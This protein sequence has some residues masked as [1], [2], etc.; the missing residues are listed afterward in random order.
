MGIRGGSGVGKSAFLNAGVIGYLVY[1]LSEGYWGCSIRSAQL[2]GSKAGAAAAQ[3]VEVLLRAALT[4]LECDA[5]QPRLLAAVAETAIEHQAQFAVQALA[6]LVRAKGHDHRLLIGLDQFEELIDLRDDPERGSIWEA[7][8]RFIAAATSATNVGVLYTIQSNREPLLAKDRILGPIF[9]TGESVELLFPTQ[10]LQDIITCPFQAV[11]INLEPDL[12]DEIA[13]RIAA[14]YRAPGAA[15]AETLLPLVSRMLERLHE[16]ALTHASP[17][18]PAPHE[19]RWLKHEQLADMSQLLKFE[20]AIAVDAEAAFQEA[21]QACGPNWTNDRLGELLRRLVRL[22][23]AQRDHL[24]LP[25]AALPWGDARLL[26]EALVRRRLLTAEPGGVFQ[27]AHEAVVRSWPT[28]AAWLDSER[29]LMALVGG[30]G[31]RADEWERAGRSAQLLQGDSD[32]AAELLSRWHS[33]L[34]DFDGAPV[35]ASDALLRDFAL[36]L[37]MRDADPKRAVRG[38]EL[39]SRHVHLAASYGDLVLLRRFIELD[40]ECVH[41]ERKDRRSPLFALCRIGSSEGVALLL[42]AGARPDVKDEDGWLPL[43]LAA[44][45]GHVRCVEALLRAGTPPDAIGGEDTTALDLAVGEAHMGVIELLL[46]NRVE[47]NRVGSDGRT[48]L[49]IAAGCGHVAVVGRL[50]ATGADPNLR[51][52]RSFTP[53]HAAANFMADGTLV[54][55][56]ELGAVPDALARYDEWGSL[57]HLRP[58]PLAAAT[59]LHIAC[60]RGYREIADQLLKFFAPPDVDGLPSFDDGTGAL[61]P[62]PEGWTLAHLVADRGHVALVDVLARA[63]APIDQPAG[64]DVTPLDIALEDAHLEV[65]RQLILAGADINRSRAGVGTY[66]QRVSEA[67]Q[68]EKVTLL[69]ELGATVDRA[70]VGEDAALTRAARLGRLEVVRYLL[71]QG[72]DSA[73]RGE[74]GLIALQR[75]VEGNH[76]AVARCLLEHQPL[77]GDSDCYGRSVLHLACSHPTGDAQ[78]LVELLLAYHHPVD[79]RDVAGW[80]P[81]HCAAQSGQVGAAACLLRYEADV[82]AISDQ[83]ALSALQVAAEVGQ[84]ELIALLLAAGA[85][86]Q[87]H[88]P[89]RA[90][91]VVL[92]IENRN[93]E[94]AKLLLEDSSL[95]VRADVTL[96]AF[97]VGQFH[98]R[99]QARGLLG[100]LPS[101]DEILLAKVLGYQPIFP[102]SPTGTT[103]DELA[104]LLA[105]RLCEGR[106]AAWNVPPII[107]GEWVEH[108]PVEA[109]EL[110]TRPSSFPIHRR[111]ELDGLRSLKN[112]WA[113]ELREARIRGELRTTLLFD[114][115]FELVAGPLPSLGRLRYLPVASDSEAVT[116]LRLYLKTLA[117]SGDT[118]SLFEDGSEL[119]PL[120]SLSQGA[121]AQAKRL[122]RCA[123]VV[124]TQRQEPMQRLPATLN[125]SMWR[126][127]RHLWGIDPVE[128]A[129]TRVISAVVMHADGLFDCRFAVTAQGDVELLEDKRLASGLAR[130][131]ETLIEGVRGERALESTSPT[132]FHQSLLPSAGDAAPL[133]RY[134]DHARSAALA[135]AV[136]TAA[137]QEGKP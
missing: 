6:E 41:L 114:A 64:S 43:H 37:I 48:A 91:A 39:E 83:P 79:P 115:D 109:F 59:P 54:A 125:L 63:G 15:H 17:I 118:F 88:T 136:G 47:V 32:E 12:A 23:G 131:T 44:H 116:L 129:V 66:L 130:W 137:H 57:R 111:F 1:G 49:V 60:A 52:E 127:L 126:P 97:L 132:L 53:L 14:F 69:V 105:E 108:P 100:D 104:W 82:A 22:S 128:V 112:G 51:G 72:A 5:E 117:D 61:V 10:S 27:L 9:R 42:G 77:F 11:R 135:A 106:Q 40:P 103:D 16:F 28:A 120:A 58:G 19:A 24:S 133:R 75:A 92:A 31:H 20:T 56:L 34:T 3:V 95:S 71:A 98:D 26:A 123:R 45:A 62:S 76:L 70:S 96:R 2:C 4:A 90:Q 80:T 121:V 13:A 134:W 55:L 78:P 94:A 25:V 30:L 101:L 102:D 93:Y 35:S 7:I 122:A 84:T 124:S 8:A 86:G 110:L 81:L 38:S 46:E 85:D 113:F 89:E 107:E 73:R 119:R 87:A 18:E 68:L 21:K 67:G 36:A 99:W 65:A 29:H 33:V 74:G 50:V